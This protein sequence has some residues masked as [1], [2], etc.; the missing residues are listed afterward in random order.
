MTC[1]DE[2]LG[3]YLAYGWEGGEKGYDFAGD[4]SWR[5]EFAEQRK[6]VLAGAPMPEWWLTP[7]GERGAAAIGGITHDKCAFSNPASSTIAALSQTCRPTARSKF[8]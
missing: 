1:S 6:S 7:S 8:R 5:T 2:H 4:E 3:E